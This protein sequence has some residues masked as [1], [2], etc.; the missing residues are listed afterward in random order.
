MECKA[1]ST[2]FSKIMQLGKLSTLNFQFNNLLEIFTLTFFHRDILD[3]FTFKGIPRYIAGSDIIYN[4]IIL[5]IW[6]SM[7]RFVLKLICVTYLH[8]SEFS[9]P[10][11]RHPRFDLALD[12]V[13]IIVLWTSCCHPQFPCL[14]MET[15]N[16]KDA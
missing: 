16:H 2:T 9:R 10:L 1:W 14:L 7:R 11:E 3:E 12:I 5:P 4:P 6:C 8:L 13:E 15:L